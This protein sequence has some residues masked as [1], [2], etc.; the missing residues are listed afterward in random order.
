[1]PGADVPHLP[2]GGRL[3]GGGQPVWRPITGNASSAEAETGE[4]VVRKV[5]L[6]GAQ[7]AGAVRLPAGSKS[8]CCG[9][10]GR[11]PENDLGQFDA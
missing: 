9:G 7:G 10:R 2:P 6:G 3:S 11:P 5:S 8:I 4:A 1:M